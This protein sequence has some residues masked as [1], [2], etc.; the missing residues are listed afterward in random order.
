M[1]K[2][3]L[4]L[5]HDIRN[6][7]YIV[8]SLIESHLEYSDVTSNSS[9][10]CTCEVSCKTELVLTKTLR[11]IERV[12]RTLRKLNQI[13]QSKFLSQTAKEGT[14]QNI[15]VR[16]IIRRVLRSLRNGR[17]FEHLL[18]VESVPSDLPPVFANFRDL[19]EIFFNLVVNAVQ[20]TGP[21]GRLL[22]RAA[23]ETKPFS[24]VTVAFQDTGHGISQDALPY[25]FEPFYT[26]RAEEGG[27]GFGL[28][29]VKQL[30]ERNGG[31]IAVESH[32]GK[33]TIFRLVFPVEP[34][35]KEV[36]I[37]E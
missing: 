22:I 24:A 9:N 10:T 8:K 11:E 12:L 15:S 34:S 29:I 17:Y 3:S 35:H 4:D 18:L 27:V 2:H 33:G 1:E 16:E 21:G 28:Y 32:V 6:P 23:F 26:G 14:R 30:V 37:A 36:L 5:K 25:I 19:E 13:A 7:L 20:A 31:R